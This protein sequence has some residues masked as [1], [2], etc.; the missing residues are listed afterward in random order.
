MNERSA[1]EALRAGVPNRAAIRLLGTHE[2]ELSQAFLMKLRECQRELRDGR[3]VEGMVFAGGF[4]SGKSHLLG[5]LR[6]LALQE[7]FIVSLV[8][9][10][11]ETPL[12][13]PAKLYAAAV[14]NAEVPR[15]NDD[16]MTAVMARL[17]PNSDA[18][19]DL[20]QWASSAQSRLSPLFAA[21]L[22]LIPKKQVAP[23]DHAVISRFYGG[24]KLNMT[25]VKQWLRAA[26]AARL[27][28]LKAVK[29]AD[30]ALQRLRFAPRLF[31]AAGYSGWCVLLDEV[32]LIGRYSALQRGK[33][34]AELIR[35]LGV[36]EHSGVPGVIT[37]CAI[38][39]DF[40]DQVI[41]GRRDS[42][43]IPQKLES[44]G[45]ADVVVL[46]K[47]GI[48]V[49][50]KDQKFLRQPDEGTLRR[51]LEKVRSFYQE[52]YG[53]T[54]PQTE[55]GERLAGKSIRQYI[56]SW[57]TAWD[58]QRLYEERPEIETEEVKLDYSETAEIEK[59]PEDNGEDDSDE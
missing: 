7:N 45:L 54:P 24:G 9:V 18:F 25:T 8:P 6:E 5:Y 23:E 16:V 38:T 39:D 10:S 56:K 3:H 19:D 27:F 11:K 36:S 37:V 26:G 33:S 30:L 22:H 40:A 47:R 43:L 14:R 32:E 55:I 15:C 44:K 41:N 21:L 28:E 52:S 58:I 1:I 20:E 51:S 49:L 29:A 50:E 2:E 57:I 12:F 42:E 4:G 17:R 13:D 31:R 48:D 59:A 53:W 46:A 35:W 34:Y